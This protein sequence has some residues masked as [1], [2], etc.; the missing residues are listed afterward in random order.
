LIQGWSLESFGIGES[1]PLLFFH[2][3]N[4]GPRPLPPFEPVFLPFPFTL[5]SELARKIDASIPLTKD[6]VQLQVG[7]PSIFFSRESKVFF[8]IPSP[9][10]WTMSFPPSRTPVFA[11][12]ASR[13]FRLFVWSS[14]QS[15]SKRPFPLPP[16][17]HGPPRSFP[18]PS[19]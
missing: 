12:S 14:P 6:S 11:G 13:V 15:Y 7:I 18:S 4:L 3:F 10:S 9:P 5:S 8:S 16:S 1:P 17:E 19:D 2:F